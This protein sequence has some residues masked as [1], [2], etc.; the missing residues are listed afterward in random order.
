VYL[1]MELLEGE[2]LGARLRRTPRLPLGTAVR[3]VREALISLG[4][5]HEKGII[6]RDLKPDNLFLARIPDLKAGGAT[7]TVKLLDFGIAKV[8]Q[9]ERS[10][11]ALETQAGTVFGTP[12]YMSPEQ[13]QGKSLDVRSDLY[14]LGVILFQMLTGRVPFD[15]DE[16]VVV[17]ARHIKE[18]VPKPSEIAPDAYI[19]P[20]LENIVM[21]AMAK[22]P[23]DRPRNAEQFS[24]ALEAAEHSGLAAAPSA[25]VVSATGDGIVV[26]GDPLPTLPPSIARRRRRL[27]IGAGA[28]AF[29]GIVVIGLMLGRAV[30][31]NRSAGAQVPSASAEVRP[32]VSAPVAS[33]A[34]S[35]EQVIEIDGDSLEQGAAPV[36][37]GKK[38]DG[39]GAR[40][41]PAAVVSTSKSGAGTKAPAASSASKYQRFD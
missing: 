12:R 14:S 33:S 38:S 7:E 30:S 23:E 19:S 5:A 21:R 29:I 13:A 32:V 34:S 37:S 18:Q 31:G 41:K 26:G 4:E 15:D 20:V 11:D 35:G 24:M 3:I 2:S 25:L 8:V 36:A 10:I 27:L 17:M 28:G 16:A 9:E 6:H 40:P 39:V 22:D 1:A